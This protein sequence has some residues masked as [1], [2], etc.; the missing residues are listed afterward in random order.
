MAGLLARFRRRL[1]RL[2]IHSFRLASSAWETAFGVPWI[3]LVTTGR[4]SG[5]PHAVVLDVLGCDPLRGTCFVQSARGTRSQ[6]FRN[7]EANPRVEARLRTKR[8]AAHA[9]R[10]PEE[11][12]REIVREYVLA[13]PL[14]A[15]VVA[16]GLGYRGP[17]TATA[18]LVEWLTASFPMIAVT[19]LRPPD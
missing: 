6:W 9:A 13:H 5:R 12:E 8:F 16:R 19:P 15:R 3:L 18:E 2:P 4:R 7:L 14:Y 1:F 10:V 17:L 11:K